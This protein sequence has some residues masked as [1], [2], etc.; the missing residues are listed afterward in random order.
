MT[1][2]SR[3]LHSVETT[4][5]QV[6]RNYDGDTKEK[7]LFIFSH[8]GRPLGASKMCNLNAREREKAHLYILKNCE[9]VPPFLRYALK[10]YEVFWLYLNVF[11]MNIS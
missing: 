6:E 4:F 11:F 1:L 9:E 2:C 10:Q 5:S 7:K 8:G 3:C